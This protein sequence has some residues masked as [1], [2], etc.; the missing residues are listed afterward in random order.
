MSTRRVWTERGAWG[1]MRQKLCPSQRSL[2]G[3]QDPN[4]VQEVDLPQLWQQTSISLSLWFSE[5]SHPPATH[6]QKGVLRNLGGGF[7]CHN[8]WGVLLASSGGAGMLDN[9]Q[10]STQWIITP[11]PARPSN[12]PQTFRQVKKLLRDLRNQLRFTYKHK[13]CSVCF[14]STLN[15]LGTRPLNKLREDCCFIWKFW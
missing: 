12:V 4:F 5:W 15:F 3:W 7:G 11:F 14:Y 13:I 2:L 10:L 9:L 8:A 6:T 1:Q